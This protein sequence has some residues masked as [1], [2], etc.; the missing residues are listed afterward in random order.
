[1]GTVDRRAADALQVAEVFPAPLAEP[2]AVR[3][4]N[5][6]A[7]LMPNREFDRGQIS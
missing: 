7:V 5:V 4:E 1:M 3:L 6:E 2:L